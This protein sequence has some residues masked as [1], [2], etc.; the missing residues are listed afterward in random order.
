MLSF[1]RLEDSEEPRPQVGASSKEKASGGCR[2]QTPAGHSSLATGWGILAFSR[3]EEFT[4]QLHAPMGII[5]ICLDRFNFLQQGED[6]FLCVRHI[7]PFL[8]RNLH[9]AQ[10]SPETQ[11]RSKCDRSIYVTNWKVRSYYSI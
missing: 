8:N 11:S 7:C 10:D 1:A 2:P 9:I 6:H 5:L 3:E 4:H